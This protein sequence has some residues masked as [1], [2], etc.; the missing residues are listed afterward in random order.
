MKSVLL[1]ISSSVFLLAALY[2]GQLL[3]TGQL[4]AVEASSD[5]IEVLVTAPTAKKALLAGEV[6][7]L[8]DVN[9]VKR[10]ASEINQAMLKRARFTHPAQHFAVSK[11]IEEGGLIEENVVLWPS[12]LNFL[13]SILKTNYRAVAVLFDEENLIVRMLRPGS[14]IDLMLTLT[15]EKK[16]VFSDMTSVKLIAANVRVLS[17]PFLLESDNLEKNNIQPQTGLSLIL[18]VTPK[19]SE[20]IFLA[21]KIGNL[22][23]ILRST[24]EWSTISVN[25]NAALSEDIRDLI[26][27]PELTKPP[28]ISDVVPQKVFIQRGGELTTV[29]RNDPEV[30]HNKD[31]YLNAERKL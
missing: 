17:N 3:L 19:Q 7:Y 30:S 6:L 11:N 10:P 13:P 28:S 20:T 25:E 16:Q 21:R 23:P 1:F 9:W 18:E 15:P 22:L 2:L 12:E 27:L 29:I 24:S 14:R 26:L 8:R 4:S 5:P 31:A